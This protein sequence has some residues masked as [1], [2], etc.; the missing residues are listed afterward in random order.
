[1]AVAM[2]CLSVALA[3]GVSVS[4]SACFN[5]DDIFLVDGHV[6][7]DAGVDGQ[8]VLLLRSRDC[9]APNS[10]SVGSRMVDAGGAFHF[11]V[12]RAQAQPLSQTGAGFCFRAVARFP[13]GAESWND[14]SI[15]DNVD[16]G[17]LTD[18]VA[19]LSLDGG[20][21]VFDPLNPLPPLVDP[22]DA[23]AE[24]LDHRLRAT[25]TDGGVVWLD[26]DRPDTWDGGP[27]SRHPLRFAAFE[28]EDFTGQYTL[29]MRAASAINS[30]F[31]APMRSV[32]FTRA[33]EVPPFTGTLVPVSRG[34]ECPPLRSPCPL[35]D[36]LLV[37][38]QFEGVPEFSIALPVA[39]PLEAVVL[40]GVET[41][42]NDDNLREVRLE[43]S[44][45]DGGLTT[46]DVLDAFSVY[47]SQNSI[48]G[49][50]DDG[51]IDYQVG[52]E[53]YRV[54]PVDEPEAISS[55]RVIFPGELQR[56]SE[57]S[58]FARGH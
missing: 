12:F 48:L 27:A 9:R 15:T 20:V 58:L 35:T 44:L 2:R 31:F 34:L 23:A 32:V 29:T 46:I 43:L 7:S 30:S 39:T 45:G 16:V 18:W 3:L 42:P 4:L 5:P 50:L 49:V 10:S 19:N 33:A 40:R 25:T 6:F 38:T 13:T 51:G 54:I 41:R 53:I 1:M 47:S 14:F 56:A 21:V 28:M 11:E 55:V 17:T 52:F 26:D 36:G 22:N 8:E 24:Q 37:S 57:V